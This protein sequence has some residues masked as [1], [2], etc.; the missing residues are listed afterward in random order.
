MARLEL[1]AAKATALLACFPLSTQLVDHLLLT[2]RMVA[3]TSPGRR[4]RSRKGK[5][6]EQ[7]Y[8]RHRHR[9]PA[10]GV[11]SDDTLGKTRYAIKRRGG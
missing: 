10:F 6:T 2:D 11:D 3:E 1:I 5:T 7:T 4:G 9:M 8:P